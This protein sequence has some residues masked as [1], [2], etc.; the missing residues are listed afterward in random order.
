M[1]DAAIEIRDL[2]VVR[3]GNVVLPGLSAEVAAGSVTGLLGP[4][5]SGKSTLI[6]AIVGVQIVAGGSVLVLGEPAGTP[7]SAGASRTSR[8]RL[9][10]RG[11][12]ACARTSRYFARVLG[13]PRERVTTRS[14]QSASRTA[15]R[16]VQKGSPAASGRVPRSRRRCSASPR[17]SCSTSRPSARIRFFAATVELL[18]QPRGRRRDAARLESR[19]GRGRSLRRALLLR[20]RDPRDGHARRVARA[21]RNGDLDDAFLKLVEPARG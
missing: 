20:G 8:R 18:P 3:G 10:L 19:D 13:L 21:N 9:G 2:H 7:R 5:G 4:S 17:C 12:H 14:R 11:S 6:R 15:D 16:V 1:A